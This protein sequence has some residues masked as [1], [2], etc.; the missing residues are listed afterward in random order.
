MKKLIE[1]LVQEEVSFKLRVFN[2]NWEEILGL[3]ITTNDMMRLL[4]YSA[5]IRLTRMEESQGAPLSWPSFKGAWG[6]TMEVYDG[7]K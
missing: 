1:C 7:E 4:K 5:K 2:D 3:S 6:L